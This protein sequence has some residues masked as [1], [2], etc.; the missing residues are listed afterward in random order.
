MFRIQQYKLIPYI[1]QTMPILIVWNMVFLKKKD[2]QNHNY[3]T[4][5]KGDLGLL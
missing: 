5:N 1:K 3:F 2:Y 4:A